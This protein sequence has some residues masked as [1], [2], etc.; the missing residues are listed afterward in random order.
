M[1]RGLAGGLW[2]GCCPRTRRTPSSSDRTG[3]SFFPIGLYA[4]PQDR[5]DDAIYR[6]ARDAGFNFLVGHEA[7]LGFARSFD[8]PGGPPDPDA[9]SRRGSLLDLSK[10]PDRK[11]GLLEEMVAQQEAT[12]GV[13]VWQ[14]PDEPNDFPFGIRPGPTPE[15]LAKGAALLRSKS[16]HPL[17]INF[18]PTGDDRHPED[19]ARLR[20]YLAVPDVVSVDIYPVGGGSDLQQSPFAE[21]GRHASECSPAT[22]CG[23]SAATGSSR[24]RSGWSCKAFGWGDLARASKPPEPWTGR[25]PTYVEIRFMTFDAIINGAG[26]VIYW[27]L[28]YLPKGDPIMGVLENGRL[29]TPRD[30]SDLDRRQQARRPRRQA[31]E[32]RHRG[33]RPTPRATRRP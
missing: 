11:R 8:I 31:V 14:G 12:P 33:G 30:S 17:W 4:F 24:S 26:G 19:F 25:T 22:S 32:P 1:A 28:P 21:R 29:R 6:E 23:W 27:G 9:K 3:R 13:V 18:G 10:Q 5:K 15:G 2:R 16:K 7:K 20:P